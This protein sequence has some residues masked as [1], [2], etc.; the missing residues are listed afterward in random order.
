ME[1]IAISWPNWQALKWRGY[2]GL[3]RKRKSRRLEEKA[4]PYAMVLALKMKDYIIVNPLP[5][6]ALPKYPL[7]GQKDS[8]QLLGT[9]EHSTCMHRKLKIASSQNGLKVSS[10]LRLPYTLPP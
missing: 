10:S 3:Q 9:D 2:G 6:P 7:G 1:R 4:K 5:I 8:D